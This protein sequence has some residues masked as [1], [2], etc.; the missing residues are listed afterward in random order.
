MDQVSART[1]VESVLERAWKAG[2]GLVDTLTLQQRGGIGPTDGAA[3]A[4]LLV[5]DGHAVREDTPGGPAWRFIPEEDRGA[6]ETGEAVGGELEP[7][8]VFPSDLAP[9]GV[10]AAAAAMPAALQHLAEAL[11]ANG[12]A[13]PSGE[14]RELRLTNHVVQAIHPDTIGAM[15]LAGVI[16]AGDAGAVFTLVVVP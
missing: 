7:P 13:R 4:N 10:P 12:G 1:V 9:V 14:P 2:E 11:A 8:A 3:A 16:E 6:A 15:V 5:E